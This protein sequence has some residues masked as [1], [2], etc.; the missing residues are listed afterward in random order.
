MYQQLFQICWSLLKKAII[1]YLK[2][3]KLNTNF[4]HDNVTNNIK[5]KNKNYNE[6]LYSM[7]GEN[8]IKERTKKEILNIIKIIFLK[9]NTC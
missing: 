3:K 4:I 6:S 7:R 8:T 1:F 2:N 5:D 9:L